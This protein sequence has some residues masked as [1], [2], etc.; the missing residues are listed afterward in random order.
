MG[1]QLRCRKKVA[2]QGLTE[3]GL[4]VGFAALRKVAV[5]APAAVGG[6]AGRQGKMDG[7]AL[8]RGVKKRSLRVLTE[9]KMVV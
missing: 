8:H 7:S 1:R 5:T 6:N 4:D 9:T 3:R 2:S